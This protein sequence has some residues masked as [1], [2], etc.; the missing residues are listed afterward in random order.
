MKKIKT[1]EDA[2]K[3]LGIDPTKLP[4]VSMLP[5]ADGQA[6]LAQYKLTVIAR[7]LNGGWVPDW[8]N[9][10]FDKYYPWFRMSSSPGFSF[11]DFDYVHSFS[12]VGSRLCYKS[13]EL[14]EYAGKQFIDLYRDLMII[15]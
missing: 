11:Y 5:E 8:D 2:C 7:A 14:A 4:D 1:F 10:R 13:S 6:L 12:L 9:G 3:K 15:K